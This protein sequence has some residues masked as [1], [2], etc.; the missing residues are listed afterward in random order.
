MLYRVEVQWGNKRVVHYTFSYKDA[1]DWMRQ[2][3]S[4]DVFAVVKRVF[5][6]NALAVRYHR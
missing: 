6:R 2:Y 5:H 4:K 1:L 3:P